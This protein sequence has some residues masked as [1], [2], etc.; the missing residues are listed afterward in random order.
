MN[1]RDSVKVKLGK[2]EEGHNESVEWNNDLSAGKGEFQGGGIVIGSRE[3][4][5]AF[6]K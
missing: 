5:I 1:T 6:Q 4:M 2:K 3:K